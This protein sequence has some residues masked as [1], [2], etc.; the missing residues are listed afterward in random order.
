MTELTSTRIKT[1]A[2]KLG[3]PHLAASLEQLVARAD[4]EQ[5]GYLDFLDLIVEEESSASARDAASGKRYACRSCRTTRP[6]TSS[7]TRSNPTST[8]GRSKT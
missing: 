6:S 8:S 1:H 7:T 4:S 5:L 2:T 3:L